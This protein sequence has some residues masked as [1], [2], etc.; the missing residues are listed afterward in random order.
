MIL[1]RFALQPFN[2][3]SNG[4]K[5][6]L[7][8]SNPALPIW[9]PGQEDLRLQ[10]RTALEAPLPSMAAAAARMEEVSPARRR[11]LSS[12]TTRVT[13][14]GPKQRSRGQW[15]GIRTLYAEMVPLG[16]VR[17][18]TQHNGTYASRKFSWTFIRTPNNYPRVVDSV[19]AFKFL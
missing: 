7:S 8:F 18:L 3:F 5:L 4:A 12:A 6:T 2:V 14:R 16:R 9:Q 15:T 17:N 10:D 19:L 1:F 11:T 13:C